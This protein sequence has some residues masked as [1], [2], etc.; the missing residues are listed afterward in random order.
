MDHWWDRN[1]TEPGKLP[2]LLCLAAFVTTFVVT[3]AIVRSI[4]A[5]RGPLHDDVRPGGLHVHHAVPGIVLLVAGAFVAVGSSSGSPWRVVAA[6]AVGIGTSLVLDEFALILRLEDVYW[7][8]EGRESVEMVS[9]ACGCLGLAVVGVAPFG[10]DEMGSREIALRVGAVAATFVTLAL[11]VAC[12]LKGKPRMALF[13]T[14]FPVIAWLGALRLARPSSVW[15]RRRYDARK[16][17]RA[18]VRSAA[19]DARWDPPLDRLSDAVAGRPS[20]PDPPA[21]PGSDGAP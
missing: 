13:G 6:I 14:F 7:A 17:A 21:P 11:V 5:G 15:A 18:Q 2:L 1:I 3:R 19:F 4:R 10:V 20:M 16:R 12:V 9:L 8:A